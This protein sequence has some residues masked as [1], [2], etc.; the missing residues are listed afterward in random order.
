MRLDELTSPTTFGRDENFTELMSLVRYNRGLY[1]DQ[2]QADFYKELLAP[3]GQFI[4]K[5]INVSDGQRS[6]VEW[7][8]ETDD[9]GVTRVTRVSSYGK[10][11]YWER[12]PASIEKIESETATRNQDRAAQYHRDLLDKARYMVSVA[13]PRNLRTIRLSQPNGPGGDPDRARATRRYRQDQLRLLKVWRNLLD[14][15]KSGKSIPRGVGDTAEY[16][17]WISPSGKPIEGMSELPSQW[18][19]LGENQD[20]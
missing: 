13:I 6:D 5:D 15:A 17:A 16:R 3:N 9:E 1:R 14:L 7:I 2:D 20:E 19:E 12:T 18:K 4:K 11:L 8:I 10:R